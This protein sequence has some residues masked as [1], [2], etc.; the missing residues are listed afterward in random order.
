LKPPSS[1]LYL[2][3]T[4]FYQITH[5]LKRTQG[6]VMNKALA[7]LSVGLI[8]MFVIFPSECALAAVYGLELFLYTVLPSLLPF[9]IVSSVLM[10]T[11]ALNLAAKA[12]KPLMRPLFNCPGHA[13]YIFILSI[14]SGYPVGAKLTSDLI[15]KG[16]ITPSEGQRI[17]SFCSTSGP[18]F[19]I[20]AVASGMLK[21]PYIGVFILLAHLL[22]AICTGIFA[23]F[24]LKG[25]GKQEQTPSEEQKEARMPVGFI[26]KDAVKNS[27][28]SILLIGGYI[29]LFSVLIRYLELTGILNAVG[30]V[31]SPL[32]RLLGLPTS[33]GAPMAA[34]FIE[35]T[36]GA[37]IVALS[38]ATLVQKAAAITFLIS[39]GGFSVYS[40]CIAFTSGT[41][42]KSGVYLFYKLLHGIMAMTLFFTMALLFGL[43]DVSTVFG[44]AQKPF[45]ETLL[46]SA[47]FVFAGV[48]LIIAGAASSL[49]FKR[50][51]KPSKNR[52]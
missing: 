42:V 46:D 49:S 5:I 32:L 29:I 18:V 14:T 11:G 3:I 10:S 51:N 47:Q 21:S 31:L 12:S 36:T 48:C 6:A 40:Q 35:M 9:F 8:S 45:L 33:L 4:I 27:V 30:H 7:I 34:G 22:G 43:N 17:L 20:G 50:K 26:I 44:N 52:K 15:K 19:I 39:F 24:F 37:N 23:R 2:Y 38:S 1:Y 13:S 41:G 16:R 28:A 25:E